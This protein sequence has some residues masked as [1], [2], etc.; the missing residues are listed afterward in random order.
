MSFRAVLSRFTALRRRRAIDAELAE[1]ID[2]HLA[3]AA[4]ERRAAGFS[5][6]DAR[7][8]ARKAF[9]NPTLARQSSRE[10]WQWPAF[11]SL[12]ADL[13][14]GARVLRRH[15]AAT[16]VAIGAL[17]IGI[18]VTSAVVSLLRSILHP[19]YAYADPSRL[20]LPWA[21]RIGVAH[22]DQMQ[23]SLPELEAWQRGGT[24][25]SLG[26]FT[27]TRNVNVSTGRSVERAPATLASSNFIDILGVRPFIG[28]GFT[29][30]DALTDAANV[31]IVTYDFWK[32]SMGGDPDLTHPIV[33]DRQA[34]AVIGVMPPSFRVP[35]LT[36]VG[37]ILPLRASPAL[38]R[39]ARAIVPIGRLAPAANVS[40]SAHEL[41]R[42][43]TAFNAE[44][45]ADRGQ[46]GVNVEPL[47]RFGADPVVQMLDIYL[48]LAALVLLVACSNVAVLL[49]ARIPERRRE[50]ALR[51]ALGAGERRIL[52]QLF[53][54]SALVAV[55]AAAFGV[56]FVPPTLA[57]L[58]RVV[59]ESVPF[60]VTP[61]LDAWAVASSLV[62][63]AAT[64]FL[65]GMAPAA[66][67][68]RSLRR[69]GSLAGARTSGAREQEWLRGAL[70]TFEVAL[71][72]VLLIGG[73]LMIDSLRTVTRR[74]LGFETSDL[75]T[76]RLMLDSSRYATPAARSAFY[77]QL[78]QRLRDHPELRDVMIASTI[79]LA[80]GGELVNYT[81]RAPE[82]DGGKA[83]TVV[84]D[85][86]VVLPGFFDG[87]HVPIVDGA[88]FSGNE[89][90]PVVV[91]NEDLARKLWP[92]GHALGQRLDVLAP[93][94][95]DGEVV[96]PGPRRVVGVARNMRPSPTHP[97]DAFPNFWVPYSQ[98]PLRS[99]YVGMRAATPGVA[100]AALRHETSALDRLLP[101]YGVK[102]V[103]ELLGYWLA[104]ARVDAL[105][106]DA[107][108]AIGT[109]LTVIGIYSVVAVF[110]S[111]R[112]QE[113]GVRI[114]VGARRVDI[115]RLVLD[116]TL[117][118]TIVGAAAGL[119]IAAGSVRLLSSMLY[120]ISPLEPGAF[121]GALGV[122]V[123][124]IT[125]A[126]LV[127][128]RRAAMTD[129]IVAL[130][131]D[132]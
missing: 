42:L 85:A 34:Y 89:T 55:G 127:P 80:T 21:D 60:V 39:T 12:A 44:N 57:V 53:V 106:A 2:T 23:I 9:G 66:S 108:A 49:V 65:F 87:L 98:A 107:L 121:V 94:F 37:L 10:A 6:R 111:Q 62:L 45:P 16:A 114:A 30:G 117:R 27:W 46:W 90:E 105:I 14:F 68:V 92:G 110:V 5:E 63:A 77:T 19:H 43:T 50:L 20:I 81:T 118:P 64:C 71:S 51:L 78:A 83:D 58:D 76:A 123:I 35:I 48:A 73:W 86:S 101:V 29:P 97:S 70:M 82:H 11:D 26:G 131:S 41:T 32:A 109:M 24:Q 96:A 61:T 67:A 8:A 84:T 120:G 75:V 28:R 74:P 124:V 99:M 69:G 33:V 100:A 54:E 25:Q 36:T 13:R 72:L 102:S 91:V 130:R 7:L 132:M 104:Y 129:P 119:A 18:G 88:M 126:A 1:E 56:A 15:W 52:G 112:R 47:E 40:S 31:A 93:L 116:R 4:D 3:L 79:P 128:A 38:D 103:D 115:A 125:A 113:I 122:L 95:A 59:S 22:W 17:G